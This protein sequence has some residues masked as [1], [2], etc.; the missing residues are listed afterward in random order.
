MLKRFIVCLLSVAVLAFSV[1]CELPDLPETSTPS[2]S[3]SSVISDSDFDET[4][5]SDSIETGSESEDPSDSSESD[6]PI[7]SPDDPEPSELK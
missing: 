1:G 5:S 3:P 7:D 4:D 6:D 2:G